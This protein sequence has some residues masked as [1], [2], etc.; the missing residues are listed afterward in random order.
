MFLWGHSWSIGYS[1]IVVIVADLKIAFPDVEGWDLSIRVVRAWIEPA[2]SSSLDVI[3]EANF[4][5]F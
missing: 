4:L 1:S 5:A 3:R 2:T